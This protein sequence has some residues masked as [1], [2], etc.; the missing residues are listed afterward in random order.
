MSRDRVRPMQQGDLERIAEL[1]KICFRT[2]WSKAALA[3]ELKNS[4]AHY[5][6]CERD[7]LVI[8]YAGMW[9]LFDE[10]H[11]TNVAVAPEF[12]RLGLGRR[13][14][15]CMMRAALLFGATGMTLEVREHNYAA[16]AL[17]AAL[18]FEKAGER[19]G[20]YH[21]SGESA[22]ILWNRDISLTLQRQN[23]SI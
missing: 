18:G 3:D 7:G 22:Y 4:A 13:M 2:P 10:A 20:Y 23:A 5:L 6:V 14:M 12:R 19:K 17:Y 1:E 8:A 9:V 11:V 21:D 16:Q 15:L